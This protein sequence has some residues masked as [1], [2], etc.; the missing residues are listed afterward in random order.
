[1]PGRGRDR[2]ESFAGGTAVAPRSSPWTMAALAV[3]GVGVVAAVVA[4]V[5]TRGS[6]RRPVAPDDVATP[7]MAPPP[8]PRLV[9]EAAGPGS[10]PPPPQN[11]YPVLDRLEQALAAERLYGK[12]VLVG[13]TAEVR[14]SFCRLARVDEIIAA[15]GGELR[16]VGVTAVLCAEPHGAVVFQRPLTR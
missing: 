13:A 14:S 8:S 6:A 3:A 16:E 9:E 5:V 1:M 7:V 2:R 12:V 15:R 11:P 10:S 4:L